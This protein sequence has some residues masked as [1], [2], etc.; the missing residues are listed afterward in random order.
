LAGRIPFYAIIPE[1]LLVFGVIIATMAAVIASQALISGTFTL[2]N[3]AHEVE[4][5]AKYISSLPESDQGPNLHSG[6]QLDIVG[7]NNR[8]RF[9]IQRI[10]VSACKSWNHW[11]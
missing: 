6:Y 8:R 4:T 9:A 3:E 1:E 5:L 7:R 11:N 2:V 10:V